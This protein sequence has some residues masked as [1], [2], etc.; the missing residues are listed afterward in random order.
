MLLLLLLDDDDDEEEEDRSDM[1]DR[2]G[3][4]DKQEESERR[5]DWRRERWERWVWDRC[6]SRLFTLSGM[7]MMKCMMMILKSIYFP[8]GAE[9]WCDMMCL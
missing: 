6:F 9:R 1:L 3:I 7:M 8:F 4:L 5:S 2:D